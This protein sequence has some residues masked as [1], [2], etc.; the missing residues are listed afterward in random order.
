M[1]TA[2]LIGLAPEATSKVE[3]FRIP[4]V[5]YL[6]AGKILES[7]GVLAVLGA[8]TRRYKVPCAW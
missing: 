6:I 5:K 1:R 8:G 2:S 3:S 4:A 7:A